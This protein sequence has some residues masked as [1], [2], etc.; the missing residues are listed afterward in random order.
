[1]NKFLPLLLIG[2]SAGSQ[3]WSKLEPETIQHFVNLIKIDT[4]NPPGNETIAAEYLKKILGAEGIETKML[5]AEP[6][7]ANL[8]ARIR[9]NGSKKPILIMGHTDVVGVQ[10]EKWT[11]DPFSGDRK[12]GYVFG[13]GTLDDK[14]NV[15]ACLMTM[16]LLKRK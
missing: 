14:D 10:R 16:L 8:L 1:M 12:N 5:I 15:T 6:D 4:S 9:G 13:R 7:R 3:D 2:M 11:F